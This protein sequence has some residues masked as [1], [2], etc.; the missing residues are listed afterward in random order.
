MPRSLRGSNQ[1][2]ARVIG[3]DTVV[4]CADGRARRYVNLDYAASTPVMAAV[5]DAVERFMPWYSSVHR[6]SGLKSPLPQPGP[7]PPAERAARAAPR[8]Q[9]ARRGARAPPASARYEIH[10]IFID[11]HMTAAYVT[12]SG[13]H[14]GGLPPGLP[15]TH[16]PFAV[17]H[18]HLIRFAEDGRAIE[19]SAVRDDLGMVMQLG[20]LPP[21]PPQ[22]APASA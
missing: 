2:L 3:A 20:L 15:A 16:K 6:G 22:E 10:H 17:K 11:D 7:K 4:P 19:H 8:A 12:M 14:E 21:A 13:T 5:W 18:V 9:A 1:A